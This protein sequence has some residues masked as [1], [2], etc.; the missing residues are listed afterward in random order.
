MSSRFQDKKFYYYTRFTSL[1]ASQEILPLCVAKIDRAI[2]ISAQ[3]KN[4]IW[5]IE[6]GFPKPVLSTVQSLIGSQE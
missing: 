2:A 1:R 5:G 4:I 3:E 6:K